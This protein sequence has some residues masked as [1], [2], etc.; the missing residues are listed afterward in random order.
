MSFTIKREDFT[1]GVKSIKI[2]PYYNYG[3]CIRVHESGIYELWN[4]ETI[5]FSKASSWLLMRLKAH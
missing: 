2:L 5:P 4:Y 3:I 1:E